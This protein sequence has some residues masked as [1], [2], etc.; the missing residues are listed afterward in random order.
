[1]YQGT[2]DWM[3][4]VALAREADAKASA[5]LGA[6]WTFTEVP[7]W[8]H[9]SPAGVNEEVIWPWFA[10]LQPSFFDGDFLA[11]LGRLAPELFTKKEG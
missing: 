11:I 5:V 7:E 6:G 1:L 8:T 10:A 9:A 2:K 4:E 3:F